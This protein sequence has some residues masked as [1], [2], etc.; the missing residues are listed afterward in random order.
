[1]WEAPGR[2]VQ[3]EPSGGG[4][5][6][7]ACGTGGV[8]G[9]GGPGAGRADEARGLLPLDALIVTLLDGVVEDE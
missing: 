3:P 8:Q 5:E 1:M 4:L 9:A 2:S 6:D 7:G